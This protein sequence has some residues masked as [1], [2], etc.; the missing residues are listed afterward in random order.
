MLILA[1]VLLPVPGANAGESGG[2]TLLDT[3][4]L[5]QDGRPVKFASEA[6]GGR[7][8][9]INFIYTT[10]TTVCPLTSATFKRVQGKLGNRLGK[11]V[12]L[13]SISLDPGTDTPARL[14]EMAGHYRAKPGWIWLTGK[15]RGVEQVL[16]GLGTTSANFRDHPPLV[17]VGD[18]GSGQWTRFNTLP[19]P[20]LIL[21]KLEA[22]L[23]ARK[24]AD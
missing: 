15:D 21:A 11:D 5:D 24:Q 8:V 14:R 10:C 22:L 9:A 6:V 3:V 4:L 1:A 12:R 16:Q 2:I 19:G 17:L 18:A 13:I 20:D 7:I 23:A